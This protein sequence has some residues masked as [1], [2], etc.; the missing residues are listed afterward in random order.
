MAHYTNNDIKKVVN[1]LI[2]AAKILRSTLGAECNY[3]VTDEDAIFDEAVLHL[4]L[5]DIIGNLE[6]S[7][8]QLVTS[9]GY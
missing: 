5:L 1:T 7:A 8:S 9:Y 4:E 2:D 6:E 3:S